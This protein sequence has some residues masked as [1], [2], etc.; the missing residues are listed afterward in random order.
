MVEGGYPAELIKAFLPGAD[1]HLI[2]A[3]ASENR[4][5]SSLPPAVTRPRAAQTRRVADVVA[6]RLYQHETRIA[7]ASNTSLDIC[8]IRVGQEDSDESTFI[9]APSQLLIVG[10]TG[11]KRFSG[12]ATARKRAR[13][14]S[15]SA[16]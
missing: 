16:I 6:G 1:L 12:E 10:A 8:P 9:P 5:D 2:R 15:R 13:L 7:C 11:N 4:L 3:F 14:V